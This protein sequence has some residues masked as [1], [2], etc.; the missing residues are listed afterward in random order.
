[1]KRR[2]SI[3]LYFDLL[4]IPEHNEVCKKR[5]GS[6]EMK[7]VKLPR[8]RTGSNEDLRDDHS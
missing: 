4:S 1:M 2:G 7:N 6:V 8:Y 5:F 3:G